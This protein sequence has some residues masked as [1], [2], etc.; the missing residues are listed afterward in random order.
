MGL[1]KIARARRVR[2]AGAGTRRLLFSKKPRVAGAVPAE[3]T[4]ITS[5]GVYGESAEP[6]LPGAVAAVSITKVAVEARG[7]RGGRAQPAVAARA[8]ASII[9]AAAVVGGREPEAVEDAGFAQD[10]HQNAG[11]LAAAAALAAPVS[12]VPALGLN[13]PLGLRCLTRLERR[14]HSLR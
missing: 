11:E 4:N 2:V 3:T 1:Q 13:P 6:D 5:C 12:A 8:V 9:I 7:L 10:A 14:G